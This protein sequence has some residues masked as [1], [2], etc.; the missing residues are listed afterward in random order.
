M[1]RMISGVSLDSVGYSLSGT[2]DKGPLSS[3]G[4]TPQVM[5][6]ICRALRL[7]KEERFQTV[8]EL[9]KSMGAW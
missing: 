9:E 3:A 4:A 8:V 6:T 7:K 2:L 5:E 1:Y